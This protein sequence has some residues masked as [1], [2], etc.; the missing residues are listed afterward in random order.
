MSV[1]IVRQSNRIHVRMSDGFKAK[2]ELAAEKSEARSLAEYVRMCL[3]R[4]SARVGVK[5]KA[6]E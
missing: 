4:E 2:I 3:V 5:I 1:K 6:N